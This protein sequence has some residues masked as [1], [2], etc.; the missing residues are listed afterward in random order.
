MNLSKLNKKQPLVRL[1][2]YSALFGLFIVLLDILLIYLIGLL[3][4][5]ELDMSAMGAMGTML[6]ILLVC[7]HFIIA[8][9]ACFFVGKPV[10]VFLTLFIF[11]ASVFFCVK[12]FSLSVHNS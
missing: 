9:P 6:G 8:V 3:D 2:I 11:W 1:L 12:R 10:W 5:K 7:T 4:S